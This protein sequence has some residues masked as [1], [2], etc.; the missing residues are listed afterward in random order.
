MA[1][2]FLTY[3]PDA[4]YVITSAIG[5]VK[6]S[7][8]K[9]R[10]DVKIAC[11]DGGAGSAETFFST[12][13]YS[14]GGVVEVDDVGSLIEQYFRGHDMVTGTVA[15]TVDG[16]TATVRC[17][18]CEYDMPD[19]FDPQNALFLASTVQR[20]QP[21]STVAMASLFRDT[22]PSFYFKAVGHS[23]A[24]GTLAVSTYVVQR[25]RAS[26]NAYFNVGSI[27]RTVTSEPDENHDVRL[28]DVLYFSIEYGPMQKMCY[29]VQAAPGLTFSFRNI[30]NVEEFVTVAGVVS[31]KTD[32]KRE[33]ADCNGRTESYDRRVVRTFTVNSEPL[34]VDE[35]HVY[36]QL[37]ASHDVKLWIDG[38]EYDVLVTDH[39]CEPSSADGELS[40][41]KFTWRFASRRP[42]VFDSPVDGIRPS[43]RGIFN[44]IFT[45][46]YE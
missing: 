35:V 36:E 20:V 26:V 32:V 31:A 28:A 7:T 41:V 27:I 24:D 43:S 19:G 15:I 29:I 14:F 18:Y 12:S 16:V 21:D 42:R 23:A 44:D 6:V 34:T 30:F 10:V 38:D 46:E 2:S 4:Q 37:L 3:F 1:T 45:A 9:P 40:T 11:S 39:T 13:L 25:D 17:L 8:T 5:S 22:A 33:L